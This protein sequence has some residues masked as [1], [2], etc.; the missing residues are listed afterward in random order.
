M[1]VFVF[2][3]GSEITWRLQVKKHPRSLWIGPLGFS[4][5]FNESGSKFDEDGGYLRQI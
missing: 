2:N 3:L 5:F 1:G 4:M